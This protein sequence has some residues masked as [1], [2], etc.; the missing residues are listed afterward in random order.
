MAKYWDDLA[1]EYQ[2]ATRISVH[3]FHYGPLLPGDDQLRILPTLNPGAHALEVGGGAGQNSLVLARRGCSCRV[4][5]ISERQLD[6]GRSLAR[7]EG[8]NVEFQRLDMD[9]LDASNDWN[10]DF[11]HSTYAL[12]FSRAPAALLH[13]IA[14]LLNPGGWFLLTTGHPLYSGEWLEAD[15]D[16]GIF[17]QD[18]FHPQGD[19]RELSSETSSTITAHVHPLSVLFG[20][21][22]AAGLNIIRFEEPRPLPINDLGEGGPDS[23]PYFSEEWMD[24]YPVLCKVPIVAVF[25]CQKPVNRL[26][27]S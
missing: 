17:L 12:P 13:T 8:L 14:N 5:D 23:I 16:E 20:W 11:I 19:Q 25:L 21:L 2:T 9:E 10:F 18:Y 22:R 6:H 3:N 27:N 24:L 7:E 1:K 15:E 4:L 26:E